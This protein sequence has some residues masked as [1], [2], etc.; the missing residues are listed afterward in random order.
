METITHIKYTDN[1]VVDRDYY[2]INGAAV[3]CIQ[4]PITSPVIGEHVIIENIEYEA[5][6]I[7]YDPIQVMT[8][9]FL[10]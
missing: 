5:Y 3:L 7:L 6:K 1:R 8:T 9:I 2:W 4:N 10:D